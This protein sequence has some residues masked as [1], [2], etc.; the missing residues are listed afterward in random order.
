MEHVLD[1]PVWNALT[2]GNNDLAYGTDEVK[3]YAQE[4][5]FFAGFKEFSK[6]H[7]NALYEL[8]T[9]DRVMT[10]VSPEDIEIPAQWKVVNHMKILQMVFN[11]SIPQQPVNQEFTPLQDQHIPNMLT[12]TKMTKPGPFFERTIDF[13]NYEGI[14]KNNELI[15]MA[16]QRLHPSPYIEISAVCTHPD[17]LGNGYASQLI[18]RQI[19][20]I[21]AASGIPF[22]HVRNDNATAIKVYEK[23][24][25]VI[26]KN[27]TFNIIQKNQV[28]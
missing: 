14:F 2:S 13:G 6:D 4:V 8:I 16:G 1:N 23:L 17:H 15:A 12:L 22:L 27:M 25:F 10:V 26:R 9:S 21:I 3:Y 7:F 19:L 24:G 5:A 28:F 11:G 18:N 20:A